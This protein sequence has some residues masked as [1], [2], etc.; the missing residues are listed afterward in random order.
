[1]KRILA[2]NSPEKLQFVDG[3]TGKGAILGEL[4][5]AMRDFPAVDPELAVLADPARIADVW[6][7]REDLLIP[8]SCLNST[9]CGLLS[10][11]FLRRDI[12]GPED[13]HGAAFYAPAPAGPDGSVHAVH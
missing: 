5:R 9:V 6:G 4:R 8:G 1:M 12:I 11:T 2:E 13:Y 7:T 10:R 3:W